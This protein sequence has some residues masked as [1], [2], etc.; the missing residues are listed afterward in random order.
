MRDFFVSDAT[1][2]NHPKMDGGGFISKF[3]SKGYPTK[4]KIIS[5]V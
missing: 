5:H 3:W 4:K 1:S 2:I